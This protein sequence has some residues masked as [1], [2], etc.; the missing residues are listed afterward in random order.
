[1]RSQ[2]FLDIHEDKEYIDEKKLKAI[3]IHNKSHNKSPT[4]ADSPSIIT[5]DKKSKA[6][7]VEFD[8]DGEDDQM[9][10]MISKGAIQT[11]LAH[12]KLIDSTS[13]LFYT[14]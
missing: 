13:T 14:F 1:M 4:K 2:D 9:K 6:R 12:I 5:D 11:N 3:E 7:D 8:D 10:D